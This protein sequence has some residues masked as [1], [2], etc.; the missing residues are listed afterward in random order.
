LNASQTEAVARFGHRFGMAFQM[1]DDLLD[2]GAVADL[3]KPA[4]TDLSNGLVNL[5]ALL[6]R[7]LVGK[8]LSEF[9]QLSTPELLTALREAGVLGKARRILHAELDSAKAELSVLPDLPARFHLASLLEDLRERA[10]EA[11]GG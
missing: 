4:R 3:D 2:L 9:A 6:L 10:I 7:E 11:M 5:P 1:C 8:E